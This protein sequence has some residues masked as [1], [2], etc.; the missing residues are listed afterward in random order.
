[1]A[2]KLI[3]YQNNLNQSNTLRHMHLPTGKEGDLKDPKNTLYSVHQRG[4]HKT[5]WYLSNWETMEAQNNPTNRELVTYKSKIFPSLRFTNFILI[6]FFNAT[7]GQ[8]S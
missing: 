8:N 1:M 2:T 3:K 4:K 6:K 7:T 5:L